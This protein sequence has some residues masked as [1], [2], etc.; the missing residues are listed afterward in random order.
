[1]N[2][3]FEPRP[4][5]ISNSIASLDYELQLSIEQPELT[6][7]DV[8]DNITEFEDQDFV[9]FLRHYHFLSSAERAF[10]CLGLDHEIWDSLYTPPE[11]YGFNGNDT[12]S[13][14][15]RWY[16]GVCCHKDDIQNDSWA[17]NPYEQITAIKDNEWKNYYH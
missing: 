7:A 16:Y 8:G 1:M 2:D 14:W 9:E 12:E 15:N 5:S 13:E 4:F 11:F 6:P 3:I 17:T 10:Y